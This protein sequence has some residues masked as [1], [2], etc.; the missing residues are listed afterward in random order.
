MK[1]LI[2]CRVGLHACS[3]LAI[4]LVCYAC[5]H[6][7]EVASA[8]QTAETGSSLPASTIGFEQATTRSSRG[9]ACQ[10]G[11]RV[12][13]VNNCAFTSPDSLFVAYTQLD[14]PSIL[15]VE[16]VRAFG[17]PRALCVV[18]GRDRHHII[19]TERAR[20]GVASRDIADVDSMLTN[21]AQCV[22]DGRLFARAARS[23]RDVVQRNDAYQATPIDDRNPTHAVQPHPALDLGDELVGST[24]LHG[25]SHDSTHLDRTQGLAGRVGRH[26]RVSI[27]HDPVQPAFFTTTGMH[28]Q[29]RSHMRCAASWSV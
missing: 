5:A 24:L 20:E 29:S 22:G 26:T 8:P 15:H 28:P 12:Q 2:E 9:S 14:R 10:N 21:R 16:L 25:V 1:P 11:D 7:H 3:V 27:G 19:R 23:E 18:E 6:T 17:Q 4:A 13:R